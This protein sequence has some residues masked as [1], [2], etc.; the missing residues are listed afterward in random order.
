MPRYRIA[1]RTA[2]DRL[3]LEQE[4]TFE[5]DEHAVRFILEIDLAGLVVEIRDGTRLV[6]RIETTRKPR[7]SED[8]K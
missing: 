7:R 5:D 2:A 1:F 8:S 3:I 6:R 4:W